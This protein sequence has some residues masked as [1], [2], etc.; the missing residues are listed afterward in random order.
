MLDPT[1][2]LLLKSA[3]ALYALILVLAALG[4]LRSFRIPNPLPA[5]LLALFALVAISLPLPIDGVSHG[6]A[7][8]ITLAVGLGLYVLGWLGA[9]D[10][11]LMSAVALWAGLDLLPELAMVTVLGGGVLALALVAARITIVRV[12]GLSGVDRD[13]LPRLI[14]ER[15]RIPYGLPIAVGGLYILDRSPLGIWAFL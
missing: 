2:A 9:G 3:A 7:F 1:Y 10:V 5:A 4:D 11:K 12:A 14:V 13:R 8:V 15:A 6:A